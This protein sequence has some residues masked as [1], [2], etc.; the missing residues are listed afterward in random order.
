MKSN[1]F[2]ISDQ[3]NLSDELIP[4]LRSG[5]GEASGAAPE[6]EEEPAD[7]RPRGGRGRHAQDWGHIALLSL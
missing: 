5:G 3:I 2:R 1:S 7:R 6:V 4:D